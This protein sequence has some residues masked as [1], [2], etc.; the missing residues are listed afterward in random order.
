MAIPLDSL[1]T[2]RVVK[3]PIITLYGTGGIGKTTMAAGAPAP[4]FLCTEDGLGDVEVAGQMVTTY[5]ELLTY[6]ERLSNEE[7]PYRTLVIDTLDH[8]EPLIWDDVCAVKKWDSIE[9][10]GYGKGYVEALAEW[11]VIMDWLKYLR[12]TKNMIIVM[13]AHHQIRKFDAPDSEPYDRYQLKLNEK[14]GGLIVET[15]DIVGFLTQRVTIQKTKE[16]FGKEVA[17]G[18][19]VGQRVVHLEERPAWV[20][21]KRF[22]RVPVSLDLPNSTEPQKIWAKLAG[23]LPGADR[24]ESAKKPETVRPKTATKAA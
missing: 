7:H 19:G 2:T 13:L 5:P 17:R 23:Y 11:R 15:S 16:G 1:T 22:A 10:P 3:P 9:A 18:T 4:Y 21:K 14:A 24:A 12:N 8:L 20:A 6:L